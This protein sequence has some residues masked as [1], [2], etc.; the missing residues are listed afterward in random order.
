MDIARRSRNQSRTVLPAC[1]AAGEKGG[2]GEKGNTGAADDCKARAREFVW[3]TKG[4]RIHGFCAELRPIPKR[5]R[6]PAQGCRVREATLGVVPELVSTPTGL[7]RRRGLDATPLALIP[8]ST[9]FSQGSSQLATRGFEP[10]S[11]WDS[12]PRHSKVWV[13]QRTLSPL[14][15]RC[16]HAR[17][18]VISTA[19]SG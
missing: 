14:W 7:R 10:E 16:V 4:V 3:A 8:F 11:L 12:I 9:R 17:L 18:I 6:P 2:K 1:R 13:M 15:L 19:R 5:L